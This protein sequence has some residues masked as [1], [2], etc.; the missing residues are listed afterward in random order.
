[1]FQK[2]VPA[3]E[4]RHTVMIEV[5]PYGRGDT[6]LSATDEDGNL[7]LPRAFPGS[8]LTMRVRLRIPPALEGQDIQY[9][10]EAKTSD[11]DAGSSESVSFIDMGTMCNGKRASSR[12]HDTHVIL[13]IDTHNNPSLDSVALTAGWASGMEAVTLTP[14][15]ILK[16]AAPREAARVVDAAGEGASSDL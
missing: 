7:Q 12:R 9:V 8:P 13:Q 15:L 10:I 11:A 4:A 3:S 5:Q 14:V 16:P 6:W 1:M 2:V